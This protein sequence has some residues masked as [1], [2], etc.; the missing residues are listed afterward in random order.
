MT[1]I[2]HASAEVAHADEPLRVT[3]LGI[4]GFPN[5]QG[6]AENHAQNLSARLAG[7]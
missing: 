3:M 4:R 2:E 6:G 1:T 5:V 7:M